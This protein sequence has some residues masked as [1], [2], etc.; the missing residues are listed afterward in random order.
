MKPKVY[1][2]S[3]DGFELQWAT[4]YLGHFVLKSLMM[5]FL[6]K[7]KDPR[8]VNESSF[9]HRDSN[10]PVKDIKA[11][12]VDRKKELRKADYGDTKYAQI[13]EADYLA[14]E[15]EKRK[16]NVR[17]FSAH[18]GWTNTN[19]GNSFFFWTWFCVIWNETRTRCI[20]DTS[21]CYFS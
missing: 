14:K 4:N 21:N 8:I 7:S 5:E 19:L 10:I 2:E 20:I 12:I 1:S 6:K 15:F 13:L 17:I 9:L 18:P 3:K 11:Y 16:L